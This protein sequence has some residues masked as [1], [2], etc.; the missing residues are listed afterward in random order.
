MKV[1]PLS[2]NLR[3]IDRLPGKNSGERIRFLCSSSRKLFVYEY[4]PEFRSF[5]KLPGEGDRG[6]AAKVTLSERDSLLKAINRKL[7]PEEV[8]F[9]DK[10][11]LLKKEEIRQVRV[12]FDLEEDDSGKTAV[13]WVLTSSHLHA[14][15]VCDKSGVGEDHQHQSAL[16]EVAFRET[17]ASDLACRL[18]VRE[19]GRVV[20]KAAGLPERRVTLKRA[21]DNNYKNV[22]YSIEIDECS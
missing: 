13:A 11:C 4:D 8:T 22:L 6:A 21:L 15:L 10:N 16:K 9:L 3:C 7:S 2:E 5:E 20:M 12:A 18:G 1:I 17:E 14:F 19:G